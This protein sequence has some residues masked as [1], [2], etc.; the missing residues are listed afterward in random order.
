MNLSSRFTLRSAPLLYTT[1]HLL[2]LPGP[3]PRGSPTPGVPLQPLGF[4]ET[5]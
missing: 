4:Y 1:T 2:A 5:Y 3:F